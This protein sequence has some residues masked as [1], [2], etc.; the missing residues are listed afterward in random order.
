[1]KGNRQQKILEIIKEQII[2]TQDDLQI[3]LQHA[4]YNVTQSTVSRDIKE[5]RLL[6]GRDSDGN[7]RY[8]SPAA[9]NAGGN[10]SNARYAEMI[11]HSVIDVQY[12][13]NDVVIKC[14]NGMAQSVCIAVDAL[15][16]DKMLG[17]IA[18][19][20]TILAIVHSETEAETLTSEIKA[21]IGK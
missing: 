14:Y 9:D 3:A 19:D 4:G 15:F 8:L 1:M 7:Y 16:N 12:A 6:K 13:L 20:D 11:S 10:H 21:L 2:L 5:L 18:G 17:T